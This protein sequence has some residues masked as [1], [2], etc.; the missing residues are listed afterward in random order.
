VHARVV[1]FDKLAVVPNNVADAW[2]C[3]TSLVL[4]SFENMLFTPSGNIEMQGEGPHLAA[5]NTSTQSETGTS[6]NVR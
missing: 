4:P 3:L 6:L 1:P 5:Q 2:C